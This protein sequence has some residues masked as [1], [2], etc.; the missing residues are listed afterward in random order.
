MISVLDQLVQVYG[1]ERLE[2]LEL[3]DAL[4][5]VSLRETDGPRGVSGIHWGSTCETFHAQI[6]LVELGKVSMLAA[7]ND[8][9]GGL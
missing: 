7:M 6:G 2:Q 3:E 9:P 8:R 1:E 4:I 5:V